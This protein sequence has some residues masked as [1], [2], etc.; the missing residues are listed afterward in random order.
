[1]LHYTLTLPECK[2]VQVG[3]MSSAHNC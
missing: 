2:C 1:L 3:F